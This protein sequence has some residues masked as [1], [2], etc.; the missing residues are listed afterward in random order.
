MP[1]IKWT[2]RMLIDGLKPKQGTRI[3]PREV[4][5]LVSDGELRDA[6][7]RWESSLSPEEV[8]LLGCL[9]KVALLWDVASKHGW[10]K[11]TAQR[12]LRSLKQR[13]QRDLAALRPEFAP[14]RRTSSGR[15]ELTAES[16]SPVARP[17]AVGKLDHR[18]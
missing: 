9:Q 16:G 7:Q 10:S 11:R 14:R 12:R 6:L 18:H 13:S 8:S 3:S 1:R 2:K 4:P 17:A 15:A 5:E